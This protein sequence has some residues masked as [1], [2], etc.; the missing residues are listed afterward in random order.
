[1]IKNKINTPAIIFGIA[2][3]L[4]VINSYT[5]EGI[6]I[7]GLEIKQ[8]D[9]LS[10]I[11]SDDYYNN[12]SDD[13]D[14]NEEEDFD[15]SDST[16]QND[17]VFL[18]GKPQYEKASFINLEILSDF[19]IAEYDKLDNYLNFAPTVSGSNLS[20]NLS[21][22]NKFL[23]ALKQADKKQVRIAH[24]GDSTL[25]GD[26]ISSDSRDLFQQKFGG[27]GVGIVPITSNDVSFRKTTDL[28]FSDNWETASVYTR[29]KDRLPVG[30][31][32]H[33]Y[34]NGNNDWVE[35]KTNNRYKTVKEFDIVKLF[36]SNATN[37]ATVIYSLDGGKPVTQSLKTGNKLNVLEVDADGS[38]SIKFTFPIAKSA[39]YF[40]ISL[41]SSKGVY[42]D[43]FALR[44]NSG[45]DL[46]K[47]ESEDLKAFNNELDY[48]LVILE[49]GL[50]I[51]S[52]RSTNFTLYEKNMIKVIET[53]KEAMPGAS[54][55]LVGVHDKCIKKGSKF[56]TDPAVIKLIETQKNIA[57]EAD[58]AFWNLFDAMG[59]ENSMPSWVDSNPPRAFKDYIH[60]ND[61]GAREEAQMLFD[62]LMKKY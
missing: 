14:Y 62:E 30:M 22:L 1:M 5:P 29:N 6:K 35:M 44:G 49:F 7:F 25:E 60:F 47:I 41:E 42:L 32:G 38:K 52:G 4:L 15:E 48:K 2:L 24:Y 9:F 57:K 19:F 28:S 61:I 45:V 21:Q 43:N 34:V 3:F 27:K 8:V 12:E 23:S 33:V 31:S 58:I 36:Y 37:N 18:E 11:R 51:L 16:I 17:S 56:V 59:G 26:L 40:G 53:M 46:K 50:N 55:L 20:G 10:D 13:T 39:Y 54:F